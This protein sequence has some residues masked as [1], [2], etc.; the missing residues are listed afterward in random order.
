MLEAAGVALTELPHRRERTLCCGGGAAGFVREV[1]TG[2]RLDHMRRSEIVSS[3]ARLLVTA[4]PECRMM[5]GAAVDDTRDT[6]EVLA[7]ALR[8]P[9]PEQ[10]VDA[11]IEARIMQMFAAHPDEAL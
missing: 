4:C 5:L 8:L 2:K 11:E 3:G 6:A 1:R 7:G 10:R 9:L